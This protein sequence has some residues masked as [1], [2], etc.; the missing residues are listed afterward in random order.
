MTDSKPLW[1]WDA[2]E[3]A[4]ATRAGKLSAVEATEAAIARM[5]EVNPALNAVVENL[6]AEARAEAAAL[7]IPGITNS[8]GGSADYARTL[9]T[10]AT[11][12]DFVGGYAGTN[13]SISVSDW[14][15]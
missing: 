12:E 11:S 10:L 14:Y 1:Q 8:E 7:E 2:Q 13:R 3:I 6:A 9:V 15:K 5:E 4:S